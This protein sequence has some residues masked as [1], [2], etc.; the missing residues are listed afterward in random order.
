MKIL[1]AYKANSN[2]NLN[3]NFNNDIRDCFMRESRTEIE[4]RS[5]GINNSKDTR[6]NALELERKR[7]ATGSLRTMCLL[8]KQKKKNFM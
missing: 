4:S 3:F 6:N 8:F 1:A 2:F 5:Q 7:A